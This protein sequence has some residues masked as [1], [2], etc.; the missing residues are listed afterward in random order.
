MV[1]KREWGLIDLLPV[2]R[3]AAV[4]VATMICPTPDSSDLSFPSFPCPSDAPYAPTR[5]AERE[6]ACFVALGVGR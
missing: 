6:I 5:I 3:V 4:S 2:Y 1:V